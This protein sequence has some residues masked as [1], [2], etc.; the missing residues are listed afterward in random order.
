MTT[1]PPQVQLTFEVGGDPPTA[2]LLGFSGKVF[3]HRELVKG[4][5]VHLQVVDAD[6]TVVA[7]G[8]GRVVGVA[9]RDRLDEHGQVT[10]TERVHSVKVS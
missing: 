2:A 5:E 8:Y 1:E 3:V 4:E 9:F 10:A 7:D 6:G